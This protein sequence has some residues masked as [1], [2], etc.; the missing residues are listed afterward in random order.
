V[1]TPE[2]ATVTVEGATAVSGSIFDLPAGTYSYRV[3]KSGYSSE[4]GTIIVL[5]EEETEHI[6]KTITISLNKKPAGYTNQNG[7]TISYTPTETLPKENLSAE[8]TEEDVKQPA[9][10]KE[11]EEI[12]FKD[13]PNEAWYFAPVLYVCRAGLME[14]MGEGFAPNEKMTRAMLTCVLYRMENSPETADVTSFEDVEGDAWYSSAVSWAAEHGI[15]KG[16][17]P[18]A[19][20]PDAVVSREQTAAILYRYAVYKNADVSLMADLSFYED[21]EAISEYAVSAFAWAVGQDIINGETEQML[22][23]Q[24]DTTRAQ[25][26]TILMRFCE[27]MR[28]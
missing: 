24:K 10:E 22:A 17:S 28:E 7:G 14:G 20:A 11:T 13:V 27:N 18:L 12:I 25:M 21:A 2:N 6:P 4:K 1:V 23:P 19:F 16:I 9:N 26:A 8:N 5:S 15:I 3:S